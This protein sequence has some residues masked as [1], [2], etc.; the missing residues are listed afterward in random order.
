MT[1]GERLG[2]TT[3][4]LDAVLSLLVGVVA[5]ALR[6]RIGA[7]MGTRPVLVGAAGTATIGWAGV[8]AVQVMRAD[9]RHATTQV[10]TANLA[11]MLVLMVAAS[12]HPR[13]RARFVLTGSAIDVAVLA[14]LQLISLI[15]RRPSGS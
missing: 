12:A 1:Q 6:G 5:L 9:W 14:V 4:V 8:V 15:M 13:R 10:A 7:L 3:L 2:R 11:A